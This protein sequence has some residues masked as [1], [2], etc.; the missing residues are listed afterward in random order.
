MNQF[1]LNR[2]ISSWKKKLGRHPQLE[3]GDIEE[4]EAHLLESVDSLV[5]SGLEEEQAFIQASQNIEYGFEDVLSEY[6]YASAFHEPRSKW[7]AS[8]W[9]P[10]LLPNILK[11]LLRNFKRQPGYSLINISGLA[12][13]MAC[14][15]I[16]FLYVSDETSYD[17]FHEKAD[18]IYRVDQTNIWGNFEGRFAS[19]GPGIAGILTNEVPGIEAVVRINNPA[20]WLATIHNSSNDIRYFE[21]PRVLTADSNFFDVFTMHFLE[22]TPENSLKAPFSVVI[23]EKTRQRY[24]DG[25]PALG[26]SISVGN[27]GEETSYQIT[28]VVEEMPKNSHFKFDLLASL[29]SNPAVKRREDAWVWTVFVTYVLLEEQ[30]SAEDVRQVLPGVMDKHAAAKLYSA[31]GMN[32]DEFEKSDKNWQLFLT[33]ITDIHLRSEGAGNRIGVVSD[34]KYVYVFSTIALLIIVL[35]CINFMNLSS[36]RSVHRAKEV[37]IRKTLGSGKTELIGQF[38]SESVMFSFI[39]LV[40]ALLIVS[41][42]IEY[43]NQIAAKELTLIA[44]FLPINLLGIAGFTLLVGLLAGIYPA[45]YL[46]SFNPIQA[47]KNKLPS[48]SVSKLSFSGLRNFLVVFQ[49]AISVMLISCSI[50]IYQQLNFVQTSNLGFNQDRILILENI[51]KLGERTDTFKQVIASEPG[52]LKVAYSNAVPPN[53]WYEDFSTVLGSNGNEIPLNSMAVDDDYISTMEFELV[54]GRVF[55]EKSAANSLYVI[56]NEEAIEQLPWSAESVQNDNFPIGESILFSGDGNQYE[57]IGVLKDFNINSL[58]YGI[59]PIALFHQSSPVWKGPNRF[60]SIRFS[61]NADIGALISGLEEKWSTFAGDLPFDYTFLNEQL[62]WQ[63]ESER[64][65]ARVVSVFTGLAIFIA[66]LGLL[67]LV[68]FSIEKRTKEI[69]IRK[70]MGASAGKIVLL[71]SKEMLILISISILLAIPIS[72]YLM[73]LW[74]QDFVYRIDINF[75][76]FLASGTI[77]ILLAW[78]V[79]S[80]K[81]I[82]AALQNPVN[83]LRSE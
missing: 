73:E 74:L 52:V 83:S 14:C 8:W 11:V 20:D 72:W 75:M 45:F 65:I 63:Y 40:L 36:A 34:I 29:S 48:A 43:F 56:L 19:T 47:F 21:E 30:T 60:F 26:K 76:V 6:H 16:I 80:F 37:G 22:G 69:G 10:G 54:S 58:R 39:S 5:D 17:T 4:L 66:I 62:S 3:P 50:L 32:G 55:D 33:P 9:I 81:T 77:S 2:A 61:D 44:L 38:L 70:V 27:P 41:F 46:T 7:F 53:V 64:Q 57:V 15:F 23:T 67:G 79:L 13:G 51:E 71:L 35:A 1:D 18:R 24:F 68:T 59:N 78:L 28:G 49:F 31:F 42:S 12:I 25:K 82:K